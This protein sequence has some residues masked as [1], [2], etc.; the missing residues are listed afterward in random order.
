MGC[1][2]G[3]PVLYLSLGMGGGEKNNDHAL[4]RYT[5]DPVVGVWPGDVTGDLKGEEGS[6]KP[7]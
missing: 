6:V 1:T 3:A 2:L 4:P 5:R 7:I